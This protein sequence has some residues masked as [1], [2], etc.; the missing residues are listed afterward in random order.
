[1]GKLKEVRLSVHAEVT[2]TDVD[3]MCDAILEKAS[4]S[5]G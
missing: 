2:E 3:A 1:M 4:P 5:L